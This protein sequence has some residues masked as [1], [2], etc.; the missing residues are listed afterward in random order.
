MK[1]QPDHFVTK[2]LLTDAKIQ[3]ILY[4]T[5]KYRSTTS[6]LCLYSLCFQHAMLL[7]INLQGK[8]MTLTSWK[9]FGSYYH[10][11]IKHAPE[12]Y[13]LFSGRTSNTE[14]EEATFKSIKMFINL[15]SNHHPNN[16]LINALIRLQCNESLH[17]TQ[18]KQ[19]SRL[20]NLY[21]EIKKC[22][23]TTLFSFWW[24]KK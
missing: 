8:L 5:D 1:I 13:C 12:Q 21:S 10:S 4:K 20:T 19:E 6:I 2:I 16:V 24:M 22:S 14:K 7:K 9:F 15:S 3:E 18:L 17:N 23:K 11:L